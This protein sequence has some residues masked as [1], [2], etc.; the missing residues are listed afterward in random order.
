MTFSSLCALPLPRMPKYICGYTPGILK[1]SYEFIPIHKKGVYNC[2]IKFETGIAMATLDSICQSDKW[3]TDEA[4]QLMDYLISSGTIQNI[5]IQNER[6]REVI[7]RR[8]AIAFH[9]TELLLRQY[10]DIAWQLEYAPYK[11]AEELD[12][13]CDNLEEVIKAFDYEFITNNKSLEYRL[14]QL[15]HSVIMFKALNEALTILKLK[16]DHGEL[17]YR[18]LYLHYIDP[19]QKKVPDITEELGLRRSTYYALKKEAISS[20]STRLWYYM[21]ARQIGMLIEAAKSLS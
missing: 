3:M 6:I 21:P 15:E 4:R 9:N 14:E 5:N 10:R 11:I 20:V 2:G 19:E 1:V 16:P 7:R 17:Y 13:R 8:N 12:Y 18:I